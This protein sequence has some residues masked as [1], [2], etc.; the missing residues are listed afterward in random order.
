MVSAPRRRLWADVRAGPSPWA[1]TSIGFSQND[2]TDTKE[3]MRRVKNHMVYFSVGEMI[4]DIEDEVDQEN[5]E[6][7]C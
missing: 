6:E 1:S 5:E 4:E 7:I 3:F 2:L